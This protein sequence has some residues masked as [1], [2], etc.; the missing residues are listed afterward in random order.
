MSSCLS[1]GEQF[2]GSAVIVSG[3][4]AKYAGDGPF[5]TGWDLG[6]STAVLAPGHLL[7]QQNTKKL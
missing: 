7:K 2:E 3:P 5:E 4:R 6:P 1:P